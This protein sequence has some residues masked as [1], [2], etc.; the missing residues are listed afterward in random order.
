MNLRACPICGSK[1]SAPLYRR[2]FAKLSG[3]LIA[4]YTVV[5]CYR[6]GFCF[7][8][9]LPSQSEFDLYYRNQSKYEYENRAGAPS[10][11]EIRRLPLSVRAIS[12]WLPNRAARILDIGCANGGLLNA[13][14]THG[15]SN[16]FGADP[17]PACARIA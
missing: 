9:D 11:Y 7:A 14:K 17:S 13:L 12:E 4:G 10:N 2:D 1:E 16:V 8:S 6:C 5:A 3:G 15:Y